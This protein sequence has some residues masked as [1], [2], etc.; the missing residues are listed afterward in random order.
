MKRKKSS[1]VFRQNCISVLRST[2][3]KERYKING[4]KIGN[5]SSD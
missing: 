4:E 5:R 1:Y 2:D 3:K